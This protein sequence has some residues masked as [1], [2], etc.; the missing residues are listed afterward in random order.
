MSERDQA[1]FDRA[2]A[3]IKLA[4]KQMEKS[5][6]A[7]EV[8]ASFMY[9]LARYSAWFSASGWTTARDMAGARD[10]TVDFFVNEYRRML[11]LNMDD[12]IQNFGNYVQASEQLQNKG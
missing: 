12:Y 1:F 5:V 3:F 8:S 9:G 2:D 4:N 11:E 10:E 6:E 7:G